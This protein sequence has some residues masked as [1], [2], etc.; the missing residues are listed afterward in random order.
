MRVWMRRRDSGRIHERIFLCAH[1]HLAV[2]IH[3]KYRMKHTAFR[4]PTV[5]TAHAYRAFSSALT[6]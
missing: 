5:T 3:H 1:A 2:S 4:Y 6:A